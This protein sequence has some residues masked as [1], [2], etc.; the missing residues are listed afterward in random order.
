MT[1]EVLIADDHAIVRDGLRALLEANHEIRVVADAATGRQAI[2]MALTH[3]PDVVLMDISMPDM[4]GIG[5]V[6]KILAEWPCARVIFLSMLGTPEHV[7]QALQAGASGY[8]LKESAGREVV[9]AVQVVAAGAQYYSQSVS[10][11]LVSN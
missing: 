6:R 1:I 11:L 10:E 3:Q 4:D 9:M 2:Q 5:A 7:Y 8:L